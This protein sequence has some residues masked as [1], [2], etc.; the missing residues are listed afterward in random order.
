MT[1]TFI[2]EIPLK[3]TPHDLA[4][5]D[6][7]LEAARN[8]YNA[9]LRESLLRFDLMRE[10][11]HYQ[12]ARHL[13]KGKVRNEAFKECRETHGFLEYTLHPFAAKTCKACWI[14]D[15]LD[16]FTIQTIAS[17]AFD[18]V[19]QYAYGARGKPRF[20]RRGWLTSVEGK[21]NASGIRW[22]DGRV[23]WSGLTLMPIFDFKDKHGVEAHALTCR[24]KYLR[25]VK[26]TVIGEPR[27]F[28]QLVLEG[29]PHQKTKND[30]SDDTCGLDIGPSTIAA[31]GED[32][33]FLSQFCYEVMQPWKDIKREQRAQ[34]RSRRATNPDNYNEDSTAKKGSRKWHRS[35]RYKKRQYRIAEC[36]RRLTTTRKK[37]HGQMCNKVLG[38][39]K[40]IKTEKLSYKS[41]QKN[42]GRSVTVRAP[43]MFV[44]MLTR[45]AANA[46]GSVEDINIKATKLSQTCICGIVEKKPL[47]QRHHACICGVQ[48]QRDLF[49]AYLAKHC[50][51][52]ILDIHQAKAAWSA[53][54][55]LLRRAMSRITETASCGPVPASFGIPRRQSCL[56]VKDG[57]TAIKV[58]DAVALKSES[59]KEMIGLAVRTPW[60]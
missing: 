14:G 31:V 30:I 57:S 44:S 1:D 53:A 49:S 6:V 15:H 18:A 35:S 58:A 56:P 7:R 26:R 41:F 37:Q 12:M 23:L 48:A 28:V 21:S 54:E 36:Q 32:N 47:K 45:K 29:T 20:K 3:T 5:L 2:H 38:L 22:R 4:V 50:S 40:N 19:R 52:H 24:V 8:L 16:A 42:Y 27:W 55:P 34:D 17:R 13:P 9:C 33:A 39:G 60:L 43:G 59:R 11:K 25:L 51:N 46:G 10:S